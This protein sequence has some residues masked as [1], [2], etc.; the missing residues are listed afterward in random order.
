MAEK[1]SDEIRVRCPGVDGI[2]GTRSL[3]NILT[4]VGSLDRSLTLK[5][6]PGDIPEAAVAPQGPSAY[7][8][9]ADGCSRNC[10]FCAIPLIKGK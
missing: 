8:K 3:R 1:F 5:K 2:L 10:A 4:L 9:I 6:T 7:L